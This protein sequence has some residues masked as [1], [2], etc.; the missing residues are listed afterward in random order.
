MSSMLQWL[1]QF[2]FKMKSDI[3]VLYWASRDP[4]LPW[5]A[6]LVA[7]LI[8]AYALSPIDLIPDFNP[9]LGYVDDLLLLPLGLYLVIH[10]I[11][12]RVWADAK[13]K[14]S[15]TTNKRAPASRI[16]MWPVLTT[17]VIGTALLVSLLLMRS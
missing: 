16:G 5:F 11:P 9:I 4:R 8:V 2:A 17:W 13:E 1:K 10:M 6:R 3:T 14:A 7:L 12:P 15:E